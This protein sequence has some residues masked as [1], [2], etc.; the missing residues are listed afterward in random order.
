MYK[1]LKFESPLGRRNDSI[2]KKPTDVSHEVVLNYILAHANNDNRPYLRVRIFGKEF[3][4]LLDSGANRTILGEEGWEALKH[5]CKLNLNCQQDCIVANGHKTASLGTVTLPIQLRDEIKILDAIV[6]PTFPQSLILGV[7]FWTSMRIIPDLFT[8]EWVFGS[9]SNNCRVSAIQTAEDL[10]PEQRELLESLL[11]KT[12]AQMGSDIGCTTLVEHVIRTDSLPIKQRHYP[13]SPALQKYVNEEID[14]L[15]AADIIEPSNSPWSSPIVLAKKKDGS[16]RFCTDYRQLNKVSLPDAY[17]LPFVS[18]ILDKLRDARFLTTLDI[19]SAYWHI[20]MAETSKPLTAFTVPTR[21]LF[22]WKRMPFGLHNAPAT[23][24]RLI[25]RV[26]GIDLEEFVF[27]YLDDII[28]CTPSFEKHIDIL[29]KVFERLTK[30][31]LTLS[32]E[33]CYFCK[34]ELRYLG[35]VVNSAGLLVDPNKVEAIV[36]IPTPKNV[37]DIRRLVG[38]AS[39]YRR[40]VPDFSSVVAPLTQLLKKNKPFVWDDDCERAFRMIKE[41]LISAPVLSCPNFELPFTIQTDASDFGLGAVLSQT[42]PEGEKVVCYLSRSLTK[43]ERKFS[44]TEKECL[45]VIFAIEKLRPYIEGTKF[46]VVTDHYSLKWL[47]NIKDPVGRIARWAVRL[48]QYDFEIVHRKGK[49]H[50]VPDTLSRSVPAIET[51]EVLDKSVTTDKWYKKMYDRVVK[52]PKRYPLWRIENSV[53]YKQIKPAYP[54]LT[55]PSSAWCIVVPRENRTEVIRACHDPPTCGHLGVFKTTARVASTYYWP[56][57]RADVANYIRHCLV[58]IRTKPEQKPPIGL[59]LSAQATITKPWELLYLDLVGPLPRSTTGYSYIFTVSDAF[60]KFVLLFPLRSA[61]ALAITRLLEDY[62]IL[63]FGTPRKIIVDNG[64]QLRSNLLKNLLQSYNITLGHTANYHPQANQVERPHRVIKTVLTAYVSQNQRTWSNYLAK[65]ACAINSARHEVTSFT[66]NFVLFGREI[67][68]SGAAK[69]PIPDD[70]VVDKPQELL[71]RSDALK[72]VYTDVRKR[73]ISAYEKNRKIY[74]LRRR[75]IKFTVGESVWRKNH[76]LSDASKG[77]TA[78]LADK[79]V[80]PL[81]V[82]KVL[83]PW[84]YELKDSHGKNHGIWHA[85]DL[86]AHPPEAED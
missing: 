71:T 49:D 68:M 24:Q 1:K 64:S 81:L 62:V 7:D 35:Y 8:G 76:V 17:P 57:L 53:L 45:A 79:F 63:I 2:V 59:M 34:A 4:G 5:I 23:W 43:A 54:E 82:T 69:V 3:L 12:F 46:R 28:I 80:G 11:D 60:S 25:D 32:R 48:Q 15:L 44:T 30:A 13:I 42:H 77:F 72:K 33:K 74:N 50:V 78:K 29:G 47:N 70:V 73:L 83:S 84:T 21:G 86:K 38:L 39:W 56:K 18:S 66:P 6:M 37:S 58:C 52:Y 19:K 61:T 20:P 14:R 51:I 26:L 36:N 55:E 41:R 10:S 27:V 40:F 22:Q 85:K 9:N 67:S 65:V 16:Y 31:G 75:D